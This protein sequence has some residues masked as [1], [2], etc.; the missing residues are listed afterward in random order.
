MPVW[1][2]A[3]VF[4]ATPG[5]LIE[6]GVDVISHACLLA[7]HI[8]ERQRQ[9]I[10][11]RVSIDYGAI[12]NG[13][14]PRMSALFQKM[15]DRGVILDATASTVPPPPCTSDISTKLVAQAHR[16]GVLI[17]TGTDYE[18][19]SQDAYPALHKEL[20]TLSSKAGLSASAAIQAAT[21]IAAR[22]L[23]Q[24]NELG[25]IER[26]KLADLVFVSRD[27][28][29]DVGNLRSVEF[30]VKRGVIY[31]RS[32]YQPFTPGAGRETAR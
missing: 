8:S 18:T 32:E 17:A 4:P 16:E 23:G 20:E 31:R 11:D 7:N 21:S 29:Q 6:A 25:T 3:A 28:L 1:A 10:R 24:Q 12:A 22:A 5:Q 9:S 13:D 30:T 26:G 27:P 14:D 19:P 2:H 15:R